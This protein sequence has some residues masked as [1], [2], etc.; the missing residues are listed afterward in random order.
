VAIGG[1][2]GAGIEIPVAGN[3]TA[4]AEY[5]W[6]GFGQLGAV[7]PVGAQ[8]YSS[9]LAMQSI[10]VG[11]NYHIGNSS[12]IPDFL[13]KGPSALETDTF[14]F[15]GQ[16][17]YLNQ[18]DPPFRAPYGGQNSLAPNISRETA[19]AT[20][21]A[22]MRLWKGAEAW[23]NPEI[24]QGFGLSGSVGVAGFPSSEAYKVG[25]NDPYLR[26]QRAFVRQTIDLGGEVQ[27]VDAGLNQFSGS[28]T[29]DRLVFT[30]GK[31][32]VVDIFDTNK[33]AHDPR[34]DFM[35]WSIVDTGTFDYAA[36]AW[37]YTVGAAAEWYQGPAPSEAAPSGSNKTAATASPATASPAG[38][39]VAQSANRARKTRAP[40][41]IAPH[42]RPSKL[43][44]ADDRA[45]PA[46]PG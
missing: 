33:Y 22:G 9:D 30:V 1:A 27:K 26:L 28:Q 12:Q 24:D 46:P 11:L 14:A 7:F 15:H 23:I 43:L 40:T 31:V 4:K 21:Y 37:G 35:N 2:G 39:T 3:W 42:S 41:P 29:S 36:D 20:L 44:A 25:A 17:T 5:L 18:Y 13:A 19:D 16:A 38:S 10:R 45:V 34:G 8:G 6:T 32:G